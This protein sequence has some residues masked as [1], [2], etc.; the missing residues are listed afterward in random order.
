MAEKLDFAD[1]LAVLETKRSALDT[2]IESFKAALSVGALGH[3]GDIDVSA[4]VPSQPGVSATNGGPIE[5]PIGAFLNKSIPAAVALHL[6]AV[7]KKQTA[8]EIATVLKEGGLE[9]TA[10]NFEATVVGA[11]HRLKAAEKVLHFP[12]GWALAEFY[13]DRI[14]ASVSQSSKTKTKK[15]PKSMKKAARSRRATTAKPAKEPGMGLEQRIEA[16]LVSRPSQAFTP[17]EIGQEI[18]VDARGV[19]L[20]LG[21]MAKKNK[22]EKQPNGR[23]QCV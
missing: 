10:R 15:K 1:V 5:L 12:D 4:F 8:R 23:Y 6:S 3:S 2:L 14:R 18:D 17:A 22:A 13:S 11:L 19:M 9:S 7:K 16:V 21:R 20:A